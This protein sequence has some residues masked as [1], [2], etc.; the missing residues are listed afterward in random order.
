MISKPKNKDVKI[1]LLVVGKTDADHVRKGIEEYEKRVRR[2]LPYEMRVIPDVKNAKNLSETQQKER[3][4]EAI[5]AQVEPSDFLVLLDERGVEFT[6][7]E[8]ARFVEQKMV[9]GV[10]RLVFV[11]GGP[12][13]FGDA[14]YARAD[15]KVSLSKMTFS[16]QL[17]RVLFVEQLYRSM[18]ILKGEPYHHE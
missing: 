8:F 5:L 9:G 10:K 17:V 2:Y 18:T 7:K 3:E 6:S 11:I 1:S 13:G 14:V 15:M 4:G 12:Y 16:H